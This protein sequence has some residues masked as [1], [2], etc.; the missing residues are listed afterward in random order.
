MQEAVQS[1]RSGQGREAGLSAS[2][3]ARSVPLRFPAAAA[4]PVPAPAARRGR[5]RWTNEAEAELC[6]LAQVQGLARAK[7]VLAKKLG[8][9][10]KTVERKANTLF[11][12]RRPDGAKPPSIRWEE[13]EVEEILAELLAGTGSPLFIAQRLSNLA[14]HRRTLKA[15]R[16]K[17]ARYAAEAG[18]PMEFPGKKSADVAAM[19][20]CTLRQVK[21]YVANG[22]LDTTA[23]RITAASIERFCKSHGDLI[24]FDRLPR[25]Q[26][27]VLVDLGYRPEAS[28]HRN[29]QRLSNQLA[30]RLIKRG[31]GEVDTGEAAVLMGA[32]VRQVR[33]WIEGGRLVR[34]KGAKLQ[35]ADIA[36]F[37]Q[38]RGAL[39]E[40][41]VRDGGLRAWLLQEPGQASGLS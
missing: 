40:A 27:A 37:V 1:I 8:I 4:A 30:E 41:Q 9:S 25:N 33:R 39:I 29:R 23:G 10:E 34:Q 32:S 28:D 38:A 6:D 24:A 12:H 3:S 20:G 14:G 13:E 26:Q 18:A 31:V 19:L 5:Y 16:S 11:P 36:T 2:A 22:Y 35:R 15:V 17:M 7:R 21:R